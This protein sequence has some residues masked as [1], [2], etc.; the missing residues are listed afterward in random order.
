MGVMVAV[1]GLD[2]AGKATLVA[3]LADAA[4][5]RG[6]TVGTFAFPRYDAD[7]HAALAGEALHGAH[8]DLRSSVHAMAVLFALDRS[9][10]AP[11]LRAARDAHDLVLVD[12]YV[13][14][15]AA[16]GAARQEE[17]A[18]GGFVAWVRALEIARLG[19]PVPDAQVL[20]RVPGDLAAR[21]V[22]ERAAADPSRTP[23]GY[24]SDA[25][26]QA[27]CAQVYDELVA[28]TWLAPWSVVG[29]EEGRAALTRTAESVVAERLGDGTSRGIASGSS[30]RSD[31]I[32]T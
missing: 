11:E 20:V 18:D 21:R 15:N 5:R 12:R 14:S 24:E 23:D 16:Y 28:R 9:G 32:E 30:V 27:R 7:V 10:A 19:V 13:A 2:G 1:E 25:A 3:A 8:G 31:T 6:A 22:R 4:A 26:L 17:D 29:A